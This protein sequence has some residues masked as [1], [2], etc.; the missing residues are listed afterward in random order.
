M[1]GLIDSFM[2][3]YIN[4][5]NGQ[6]GGNRG[7][8]NALSAQG[9]ASAYQRLQQA[10]ADDYGQQKKNFESDP[11]NKGKTWQAPDPAE[12]FNDQVQAMILSGDPALQ[13]RG[14]ELMT[15]DAAP[16]PTE[17]QRNFEYMKQA[18]PEL[19]E[20]QY[21]QMLHPGPSQ[22]RVSVNLPKMD[23]PMTVEDLQ[24]LQWPEG[25]IP[26][27]GMTM[28]DAGNAGARIAQTT[29]QSK[30][31]QSLDTLQGSMTQLREN[32]DA[33]SGPVEGITSTL[34]NQ[35]NMVGQAINTGLNIAGIPNSDK[36]VKFDVANRQT[37]G[38]I[39]NLFNGAGASDQ[40]FQR[41]QSL[42]PLLTDDAQAR[43]IKFNGRNEMIKDMTRRAREKG[44]NVQEYNV[45]NVKIP[46]RKKP[47]NPEAK[48]DA[49]PKQRVTKSGVKYT[50]E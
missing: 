45:P 36:A 6:N 34:R 49:Q 8:N 11:N 1:A 24:K 40:E 9:T 31:G 46:E 5:V 18:N 28:R 14:L 50:V 41:W 42:Q 35:P 19:T 2:Q 29:E 16:K 44:S 43:A 27:P 3:G 25:V 38:Q 48:Q 20:M 22:T 47:S 17:F 37:A 39:T 7:A 32:I 10:I 33:S 4:R 15:P 26:L 23:Q 13:A 30:S 21:F 12:R